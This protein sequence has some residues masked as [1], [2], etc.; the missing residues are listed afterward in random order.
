MFNNKDLDLYFLDFLSIKDLCIYP[1]ISTT[2]NKIIKNSKYSMDNISF[3]QNLSTFQK[4]CYS[5]NTHLLKKVL[6]I[7][8]ET[9]KELSIG[10]EIVCELGNIECVQ[11]F[12]ENGVKIEYSHINIAVTHRYFS[13]FKIFIEIIAKNCKCK[14]EYKL[15]DI[16]HRICD[17][18]YVEFVQ[19][20]H[21]NMY[22]DNIIPEIQ[23][24]IIKGN[25]EMFK[26]LIDIIVLYDNAQKI[27]RQ[28]N[29]YYRIPRMLDIFNIACSSNHFQ[30]VKYLVDLNINDFQIEV[31][32]INSRRAYIENKFITSKQQHLEVSAFLLRIIISNNIYLNCLPYDFIIDL[33]QF[34]INNNDMSIYI[35]L[36]KEYI[37][38]P[39]IYELNIESII[40]EQNI[41]NT[42][43]DNLKQIENMFKILYRKKKSNSIKKLLDVIAK[44]NQ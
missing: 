23:N 1:I 10:L 13:I 44:K 42:S 3:G 2:T 37:T 15:S 11:L 35:F 29:I 27:S 24:S 34:T 28:T 7:F 38:L 39:N 19:C 31:G 12:L 33:L 21:N 6:K 36:L 17:L 18:G 20:M 4:I 16:F 9:N 22:L 30:M 40:N 8:L 5:Q 14:T 25:F 32:L 26:L 41:I 43:T